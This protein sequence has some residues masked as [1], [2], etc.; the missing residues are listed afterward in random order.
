LLPLIPADFAALTETSAFTVAARLATSSWVLLA[1][2]CC[3]ATA[4][5]Q[6]RVIHGPTPIPGGDARGAGDLTVMNQR[7]A[8]ALAVQSAPPYGVPRGALVDLAPVVDGTIGRDRVVFADFIPNNWS[9]W[10]SQHQRVTVIKDTPQEAIVEAVRDWGAVTITTVYTLKDGEDQVHIRVVMTNNGKTTLA[11]LRSGMTLW[12]NAGFLFGV[13]GLEGVED[14]SAAGR[15][16]DR[17]VAYDEGWAVALHAP[18][19]DHIGFSSKDMYAIHTLAPGAS[20]TFDAWLQAVPSGD[21]APVV[22]EEIARRHLAS[23]VLSGL[24]SAISG[25]PVARPV[26]VIEREGKPYAWTVGGPD[27][28]YRVM[29]PAG[30]YDV[31][32]TAKGF[33]QTTPLPVTLAGG[34]AISRDLSGL[35]PPGTIRFQVTGNRHGIAGMPLDAR[36]AIGLGQA[37]LVGYLGRKVFF[38]DLDHRGETDVTLAPGD[39]AFSISWGRDVLARVT[40]VKARV[41]SGEKVTLAVPIAVLFD[42]EARGWYSADL[43]HHADQAEA[44]TPAPDLARSQLA[45]GLDLLFVSDHD[46]TANF[47]SLQAIADKRGLPFVPGIEI[48]TSWAH[49]NA[50]PLALDAKLSID[51][52]DTNVQAVFGEARRMGATV[53]QVNHPFIPYGY[54]TSVAAGVAPGGFD[55]A[56]D[57]L[58]I[59]AHNAEDDDKVLKAA[60]GFWNAGQRHYLAGGTDVHDVWNEVSGSTR[61]FAHPDGPLTTQSFVRALKAGHTYVTYGPLV[62]PDHMFGETLTV[63]P[64]QPFDLGFDLQAAAGLKRVSLVSRGTTVKSIDLTSSGETAHVDFPL[65]A[66]QATWYALIVEDALGHHA[67]TNPVWI[68]SRP[69]QGTAH[70]AHKASTLPPR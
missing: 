34:D 28:R 19:V 20:R 16:S 60:W 25:E 8:F 57:L 41:V 15:L 21:L 58:E 55:P 6:V 59:N 31:F 37:P 42:P 44:V 43:H 66:D 2:L 35:Q 9:A 46:S 62:F 68:P 48:T 13:P 7:L 29:L 67:Y 49:F 10:P 54:L 33:S 53:V 40:N 18:Y 22:A 47:Q 36:I 51:T 5:A 3:A 64:G 23:G 30:D 24:V 65:I 39:Y 26:I 52:S 45:A 70:A 17:V 69:E 11:G 50:Y 4:Q 27:G 61:T 32:A 38:T 14:G 1:L 12:P 56:F 63:T